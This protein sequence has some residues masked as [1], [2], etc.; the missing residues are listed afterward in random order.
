[1]EPEEM[2]AILESIARMEGDRYATAKVSAIRLLREIAADEEPPPTTFDR[3]D[4]LV[5]KADGRGRG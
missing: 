5:R 1:L 2:I 4:E 3:L